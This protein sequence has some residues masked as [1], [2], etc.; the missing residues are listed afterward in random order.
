MWWIL[1][2][3]QRFWARKCPS[4]ARPAE[5]TAEVLTRPDD[6]APGFATG[7]FIEAGSVSLVGASDRIGALSV[8]LELVEA[9]E[10]ITTQGTEV[11]VIDETA[12]QGDIPDSGRQTDDDG[13]V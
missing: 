11:L 5:V 10:S 1:P 6:S 12:Q 9:G 13:G 7:G 3:G 2:S 8:D 4:G